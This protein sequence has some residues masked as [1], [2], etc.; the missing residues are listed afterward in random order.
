MNNKD[1]TFPGIEP[2]TDSESL[3]MI[4]VVIPTFNRSRLVVRAL[5]SALAQTYG[6][7]EVIVV[8]DGSTDDTAATL[9]SFR[10]RIRYHYQENRG[11]S[12]AQSDSA[13]KSI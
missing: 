6:N 2:M 5:E 4:S 1:K 13:S 10:G 3:P 8:D 7:F 12:S 11:A 9:K